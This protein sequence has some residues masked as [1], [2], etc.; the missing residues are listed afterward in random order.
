MT[1]RLWLARHGSTAWSEAQRYTGWTDLPLS[2]RGMK[3]AEALAWLSQRRWTGIWA[4]DLQR[5]RATAE[6]VGVAATVDRRLREIDFGTMEGKTW[7]EL[8]AGTQE[9]VASFDGF[10]PP[11]GESVAELMVRLEDFIGGLAP[12]EHLVITHGGVIRALVRTAGEDHHP[13]PGEVMII[14]VDGTSRK[15]LAPPEV[16]NGAPEEVGRG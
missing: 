1:V 7:H 15:H 11:G 6:L 2:E 10:A 16:D 12:G 4:S 14:E 3:E 8:D 5:A 13:R 9:A